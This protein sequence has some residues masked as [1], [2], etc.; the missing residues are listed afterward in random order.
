VPE[1]AVSKARR[2]V[3]KLN[4]KQAHLMLGWAAPLPTDK[5]RVALRL[6]NSVLGEG[7]D[8]RLFTE[9]RDKRG[10]CYTVYA[11]FDRRLEPGSWRIYV[12]TQPEKLKQAEAVCREVAAKVAAEGITQEELTSA[13]AYAKGLF[14]VA[15]QDFGTEARILANYES[16]GLGAEEVEM[17]AKRLDAVTLE[18]CK[19][20]AKTWL[21]PEQAVVAVVEP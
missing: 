17:V 18:D 16:W 1:E 10:L 11:A 9:V 13:K 20:V 6:V 8:S 3:H 14:Q 15:R 21:K 7:M 5:D 12:G 4:K 2:A 19:R